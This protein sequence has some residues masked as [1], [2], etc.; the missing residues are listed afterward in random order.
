MLAGAGFRITVLTLEVASAG[1]GL[2]DGSR[3]GIIRS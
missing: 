1:A 3:A 2:F